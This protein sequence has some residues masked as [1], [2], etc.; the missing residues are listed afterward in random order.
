MENKGE[1]ALS[2]ASKADENAVP[3]KTVTDSNESDE[4]VNGTTDQSKTE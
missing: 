1:G 2:R 3:D 4:E